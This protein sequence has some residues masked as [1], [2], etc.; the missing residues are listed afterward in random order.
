MM[1]KKSDAMLLF[2][3]LRSA[4]NFSKFGRPK[5]NLKKLRNLTL[6]CGR[7]FGAVVMSATEHEQ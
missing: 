5:K 1:R 7:G 6:C 2:S 3:H 4:C